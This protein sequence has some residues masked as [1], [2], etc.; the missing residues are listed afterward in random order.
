MSIFRSLFGGGGGSE[1]KKALEAY[2]NISLPELREIDP[3]LYSQ[4]VQLNPELETAIEL[5]PSQVGGVTT[6]PM[7]QQA[8]M[9]ALRK[10]QEVGSGEQTVQELSRI[11]QVEDNVNRNLKGNQDAIMQ[12]L[13]MRGM[14]GGGNELVSR[15]MAAQEAANRQSQMDLEI[16]AEAE[17]QALNALMQSGQMGAQMEQNQFNRGVVKAE[18]QDAVSRFNNQ[19]RQQINQRNVASRNNA[20]Q[21]NAT[22]AQE[23]ANKNVGIRNAAQEYNLGLGQKRFENQLTMADRKSGVYRDQAGQKNAERDRDAQL[24][25]GIIEA[26]ATAYASDK[27]VKKD[28]S[29]LDSAEFLKHLKGYSY[30]YKD[31]KKYGEGDQVGVMAQDLLKTKLKGA[32][33]KD[34]DGTLR[35]DYSKLSGPILALLADMNKRLE[36]VEDE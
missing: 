24:F 32:V 21:W 36:E 17:R 31:P 33:I 1:L 30:E 13:A 15:Q 22:N 11:N 4:V 20:Q 8:Q 19:N 6:D 25:G 23:T 26:G 16:K 2:G 9:D 10:L 7:L 18:A 3:E 29:H 34:E 12:N 5:G 27:R 35:I 14:S 28:I